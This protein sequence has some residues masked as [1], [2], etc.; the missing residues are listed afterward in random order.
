[1]RAQRRPEHVARHRSSC[2]GR[3]C[4]SRR[5]V[6]HRASDSLTLAALRRLCTPYRRTP[7]LRRDAPTLS[8][9]RGEVRASPRGDVTSSIPPPASGSRAGGS[10]SARASARRPRRTARRSGMPYFSM[11]MRSIPMPQAKPWYSSGSSPQL[12]ST[13]GCTMPQPRISSQSSPSPK[14]TSPLSRRHWMSTSSDGSVN[15]K[16]DGRKRILTLIDLEE[17]LAELLEDPFQVAEMRALVD[18]QALDLVEHRRVGLVGVAA[19]GAARDDHA[20]RRLLRS[21]WCGSAPARCA[22]AAACASRPASD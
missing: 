10:R 7:A 19:I 4:A 21:A 3:A 12:R 18:H 20:D 2:A 14:R 17:R 15:G 13:F 8:P 22:C 9:A 6:G 16:N 1:M 11:A 5:R